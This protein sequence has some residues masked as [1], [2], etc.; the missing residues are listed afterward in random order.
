MNFCSTQA[1][2]NF[3]KCDVVETL[4]FEYNYSF[5]PMDSIIAARRS[6]YSFSIK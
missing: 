6:A 1:M 2:K 3:Q 4:K 5:N